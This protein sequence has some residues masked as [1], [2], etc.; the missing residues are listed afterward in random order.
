[1][2]HWGLFLHFYQP[3]TQYHWVLEKISNEC[4]R[5]LIGLFR[6]HHGARAT[7]N[8]NGVLLEMLKYEGG[9]D[10]VDGIQELVDRGQWEITGTAKYHA[11]LPLLPASESA[12]QIQLH[13]ETVRKCVTRSKLRGF[14]P[15]EMCYSSAILPA[16]KDAGA[17]WAILSGTSVN[18]PW[19]QDFV[20]HHP[21][22]GLKFLFRDELVSNR[23]SFDRIP[24]E[25][26]IA[27]LEQT[28]GA[29]KENRY[30]ITA[31]D[32]ETYGHHIAHWEKKFL[33]RCYELLETKAYQSKIKTA[34]LSQI[35][36]DYPSN[37]P[38]EPNPSS[39][40]TGEDDRKAGVHFPLWKHPQNPLHEM[41]WR[42]IGLCLAQLDLAQS[43]QHL[44]DASKTLV[45]N[46]RRVMDAALHSCQFWWASRR[47]LD[48]LAMI[49]KGLGL[50]EEALLNATRAVFVVPGNDPVKGKAD[51]HFKESEELSFR[52][53]RYIAETP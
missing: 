16:L 13:A 14:F 29:S 8:V 52:I 24:A 43:V 41:Q 5:P 3:P 11:I 23:I 32:A 4:Y 9:A 18:G 17:E 39:W 46:A 50:Q 44:S 21:E 30:V 38:M 22:T 1:M 49:Y 19:P 27:D 26:F 40:S 6:R 53:R 34:T 48:G 31:M 12:R 2:I 36:Q 20:P 33:G 47:P 37:T 15:P 25:K 42:H 35:V 10:I 28:G 51:A 7:V 45:Q